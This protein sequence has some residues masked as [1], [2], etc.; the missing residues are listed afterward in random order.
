LSVS[1]RP[2]RSFPLLLAILIVAVAAGVSALYAQTAT[3]ALYGLVL[4]ENGAPIG[5]ATVTVRGEQGEARVQDTNARGEFRF[6]GLE[7]ALYGAEV[8][9]SGFSTAEYPDIPIHI[10]RCTSIEVSLAST[11]SGAVTV[12]AECPLLDERRVATGSYLTREELEK[13]P[14]AR[15]PWSILEQAPGMLLDRVDVNGGE[16]VLPMVARAPGVGVDQN[17]YTLDGV[18]ITDPE[19]LDTTPSFY[20]FASIEETQVT[21]GGTDIRVTAPGA[22]LNLVTRRGTNAWRASGHYLFTNG[23][24]QSDREDLH[25]GEGQ[26]LFVPAPE[27]DNV[28]E[29]GGDGGGPLVK[30]HIWIWAGLNRTTIDLELAPPL[31]FDEAAGNRESENLALKLDLAPWPANRL[32]LFAYSNDSSIERIG[33]GPLRADDATLDLDAPTE[34]LKLE[35]SQVLGP[36]LYAE[37]H[38]SRIDGDFDLA[39]RG[40]DADP[41]VDGAGVFHGGFQAKSSD[42]RRDQARLEVSGF[43]GADDQSHE[44]K[45]GAAR[46]RAEVRSTAHWGARDSVFVEPATPTGVSTEIFFQTAKPEVTLD[47]T[48]VFVQDTFSI[49]DLVG[50]VGLRY[51][52]QKGEREAAQLRASAARPDLLPART[53]PGTG[54]VEWGSLTPRVGL[55]YGIGEEH[56]TLVRASWSRF[57][58]QLGTTMFADALTAPEA[59]SF[60]FAAVQFFDLDRDGVADAN[61]TQAALLGSLGGTVIDPGL[62]APAT[63]E[64][65]FGA[66]HAGAG[67]FAIGGRLWWRSYRDLLDTRPFVRDAAGA[68]RLATR[69]DYVAETMATGSLPDGTSYA[70]PVFALRP[71]LSLLGAQRLANG[72]REVELRGATVWLERRLRNRWELRA[73]G[74]LREESASIGPDLAAL[75]DPTDLV[76]FEDNDGAAFA[77]ESV[78]PDQAGVY[79]HS[80]WDYT[81]A[82]LYRARAGI[83]LSLLA[84]GREGYPLLYYENVLSSDGLMRKVAVTD[85][86]SPIRLQN[87]HV[88][89]VR[90]EKEIRLGGET[91]VTFSLDALNVLNW[92]PATE[93]DTRLETPTA[94]FVREIVSPRILRVGARIELR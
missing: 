86:D 75:D 14:A 34:I 40:G 43:F 30:D 1:V 41:R 47:V 83:G 60:P 39:A 27:L 56:A 22:T 21:T 45:L 81:I 76:G 5:G 11:D 51:D 10:G 79:L 77:P 17:S 78:S 71:T 18:T 35:D 50:D 42:R 8:K 82:G 73:Y 25:L 28:R 68:V 52:S 80:R 88:F 90:L 9:L 12:T 3:G 16:G 63:D 85:E 64:I 57:A 15:N 93:R 65:L 91:G 62:D 53:L 37:G 20:D 23:D 13:M 2:S 54:E 84:H 61:E 36:A 29:F 49:G 55:T 69:D 87:V 6:L 94:N 89:D 67:C 74:N 58:D 7:P 24:W 46:R 66:E 59:S 19:S 4:D 32:Q 72:G 44:I 70:K 33:R 26:V 92:T 48:S 31:L 38:L